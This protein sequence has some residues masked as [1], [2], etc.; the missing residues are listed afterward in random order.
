MPVMEL[1]WSNSEDRYT[2]GSRI[3]IKNM[4]SD[5]MYLLNLKNTGRSIPFSECWCVVNLESDKICVFEEI[6]WG[7]LKR[8]SIKIKNL[9]KEIGNLNVALK[10][11][12]L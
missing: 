12:T 1:W 11:Y 4:E 3:P 7:E 2:I 10:F 5:K 9:N 6:T 8:D